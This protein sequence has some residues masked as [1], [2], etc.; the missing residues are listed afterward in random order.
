MDKQQARDIVKGTLQAPFDKNRF[1]YFIENLLNSID[2]SEK[3][4]FVNQGNYIPDAYKQYVSSLERIGK[5]S[6]G[7]HHIDILIV[8]LKKETSIERARTMQ[9][10]FIARY[11][12]GSRGGEQKDAALVAFVSPDK[13]DWRFSLVKMDYRFED[14]K[15]GK[16]KV[17]EEFT[18]ARRWSFLVGRNENSHTAQARLLPI[19]ADDG[20]TPTLSTLEDAFNIEKVTREFFEKYRELFLWTKE[21]FD[22]VLAKDSKIKKDFADKCIDTVDF[23]KKLLGQ[24]IFLYFLQ[25]KGWFGVDRDEE[26]GTGS[27]QFLRELFEKKHG[28]YKNFFNDILEPLFYDALRI[29][30]RHD[31]HYYSRFNCKIPFLNGGLFDPMNN[32]DWVRTD[33]LISNDLFSNKQKTKEGDTGNGILDVFDRYNFTVKEDEPLER[34]VAIDPEMLGKVFENLLEIK[35][36]KSKG[37]YYTPREIVHYMCRQSLINYLFNQ[38]NGGVIMYEK[39]GIM[40]TDLL[41]NSGKEG[42]LDLTIEHRETAMLP[43]KD[44]ETFIYSGER[45]MENE[46][47]V[48]KEGRETSTYYFQLP[49][50]IRE[51]AVEIDEKLSV[52]KVCDPAIGS[53]AFPV[54]M[55]SEI[56]RARCVLNIFIKGDERT[57]YNFKRQCIENSL[58]GVDIDSGAVEIAKL[59]LW[60]SLIVDEDDIKNIKPLPNLDYKIVCGDSLFGLP[61]N[62]LPNDEITN[63][64]EVKKKQYFGTVSPSEKHRIRETVSELFSQLMDNIKKYDPDVAD[65]KFDF[66]THFSEVFHEKNGFDVVIANPPYVR[67]ESI[68]DVK[69]FLKKAY[70]GFYCGTADL[71][72]YFY[73]RGIDLL[74]NGAHL[75]FIAPNKFMR[76]SYGKNT[77]YLLAKEVTPHQI[78]DFGD[79]PIFDATTYP[80][81]VLVEKRN[82]DDKDLI[83]A[84]TFT[85]MSQIEKPEQTLEEIGFHISTDAL[86]IE[87]W[88]LEKPHILALM[89]KLRKAGKPLGEYV[90]GRF[91]YGI[92]TGLNEAFVI[93]EDT[94]KKLVTEDPKSAELIKPWLRGR[95]IK[96]WKAEW[97]GLYLILISSSANKEWP[98]SKENSEGKAR[99]IFARTFSAI[100]KH[101]LQYEDKLQKR[102]DQGQFW[103]ELRSCAY[104]EEFERPKIVYPDIAQAAEFTWDDS[105]SFL[106]NTAYIIPTDEVWLVGLLNS[107]LIWWYYWNIS[108]TIRGGF[109]R[110]IAQYMETIPIPP[111]TDAQKNSINELVQKIL[112]KP[113]SPTVPK[114]EDE[115]NDMVYKL[116]DLTPEEIAIVEVRK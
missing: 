95:D 104:Y 33:I 112:A 2:A 61:V 6:T 19:I 90:N 28:D 83:T 66:H 15:D 59:R 70:P 40:Q 54:G 8:K 110:F 85:D 7:E 44:I 29:D 82:P 4:R 27:K 17:K 101:L 13:E 81:I 73:K 100:Y 14:G 48:L 20:H 9:R 87:G 63:E 36:R 55:M 23:A 34:E 24:I 25:K 5:Y 41:G 1:T 18:P 57:T 68:K 91:Y 76:A 107:K 65:V 37:T 103:W 108:S 21:E 43:E 39:P 89:D 98:W 88:T 77:R 45:I 93:N 52:I 75:C 42:Q 35:D 80:A 97:A 30:R 3:A 12:N 38:F 50:S 49:E 26:W 96:K 62:I 60:L 86:K 74:R 11:L 99:K 106:G 56:V 113:D 67:Q 71:Y 115:I 72:T 10:N 31:D 16:M 32:Y 94:K 64:L 47:R 79:L 111:A 114:L 109:V 69:I 102:D 78:I 116:Y 105:K 46:A 92:K 84:A 53:G 51:Y 22:S 58:Y